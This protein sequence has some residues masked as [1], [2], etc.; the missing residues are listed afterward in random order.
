MRVRWDKTGRNVV[1]SSQER[2]TGRRQLP[3]TRRAFDSRCVFL[4]SSAGEFEI[5]VTHCNITSVLCWDGIRRQ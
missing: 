1:I 3:W 4:Y 5:R 2:T